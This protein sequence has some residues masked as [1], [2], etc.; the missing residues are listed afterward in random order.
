LGG[1]AEQHH[2]EPVDARSQQVAPHVVVERPHR[3]LGVDRFG[4]GHQ[5]FEHHPGLGRRTQTE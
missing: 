4:D 2:V 1:R 5:P 3:T